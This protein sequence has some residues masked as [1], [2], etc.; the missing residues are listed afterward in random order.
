MI[1]HGVSR[2][3]VDAWPE[4]TGAELDAKVYDL[5][6]QH[7]SQ[8]T[9]TGF[10]VLALDEAHAQD[11]GARQIERMFGVGALGEVVFVAAMPREWDADSVA[12]QMQVEPF[13]ECEQRRALWAARQAVT[14]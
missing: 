7:R 8:P 6:W 3:T 9:R 1:A 10:H 12:R 13:E 5:V 14:A 2:H 11:M 4:P